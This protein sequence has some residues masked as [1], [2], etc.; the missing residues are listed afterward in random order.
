VLVTKRVAAD[1]KFINFGVCADVSMT[2]SVT[3]QTLVNAQLARVFS[4]GSAGTL[5]TAYAAHHADAQ[6]FPAKPVRA[7]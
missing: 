7:D 4:L 5:L 1:W 6:T 2:I 3:R